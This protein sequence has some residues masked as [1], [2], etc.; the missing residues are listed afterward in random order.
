VRGNTLKKLLFVIQIIVNL[1]VPANAKDISVEQYLKLIL[2]GS[3]SWRCSEFLRFAKPNSE[4][5]K[6]SWTVGFG[7]LETVLNNLTF[8]D[9]RKIFKLIMP[10]DRSFI[11]FKN[12]SQASSEF[13]STEFKLGFLWHDISSQSFE[14]IYKDIIESN[15]KSED[16]L[17]SSARKHYLEENCVYP[18]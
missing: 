7:K 13:G 2:E 17:A 8:D 18:E 11:A 3:A 9:Q 16:L 1:T 15:D 12:V 10:G 4:N 6:R 5:W 14:L